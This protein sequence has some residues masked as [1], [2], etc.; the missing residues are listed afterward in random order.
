MNTTKPAT[1]LPWST[2]PWIDSSGHGVYRKIGNGPDRVAAVTVYGRKRNSDKPMYTRK[3]DGSYSGTIPQAD[4]DANAAYIVHAANAYPELVA[5]LRMALA[6]R[7]MWI[8]NAEALL[9]RL[10]ALT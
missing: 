5:A 10:G 8:D 9:A 3:A 4:A 1:P 6:A 7:P 2:G